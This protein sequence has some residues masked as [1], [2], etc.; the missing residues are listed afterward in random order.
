MATGLPHPQ[1]KNGDED[2][3][4]LVDV[5]SAL[6]VV[7]RAGSV[8]GTAAAGRGGLAART[9]AVHPAAVRHRAPGVQPEA[10]RSRGIAV[11]NRQQVTTSGS[12][13]S[14]PSGSGVPDVVRLG[15]V[16]GALVWC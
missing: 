14:A 12:E 5:K 16:V 11:I 15:L 4:A 7:C 2:E 6:P 8:G 1:W 10:A 9:Q 13:S 3:P